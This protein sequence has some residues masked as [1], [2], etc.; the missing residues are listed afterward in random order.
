M[1]AE[2]STSVEAGGF[3]QNHDK[4]WKLLDSDVKK[5][6]LRLGRQVPSSMGVGEVNDTVESRCITPLA[7][8]S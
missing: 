1:P 4:T 6:R 2:D 7:T 3:L 5:K 8:D